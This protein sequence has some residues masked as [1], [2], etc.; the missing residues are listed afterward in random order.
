MTL[1]VA[2][3]LTALITLAWACWLAE[4]CGWLL[5]A[6]AWIRPAGA[7]S[8]WLTALVS[9]LLAILAATTAILLW[10]GTSLTMLRFTAV[11][12]TVLGVS[13]PVS[14]WFWR[15]TWSGHLLWLGPLPPVGLPSGT[16]ELALALGTLALFCAR[17]LT[18]RSTG[19]EQRRR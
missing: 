10:Q 11:A 3:R 8:V 2:Q 4:W 15:L 18:P 5:A 6:P 12:V 7:W 16:T 14:L 13:G 17:R 1:T 19:A 9:G